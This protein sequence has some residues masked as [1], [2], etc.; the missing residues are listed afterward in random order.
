MGYRIVEVELSETI[1]GV[2]LEP[3]HSG[4]G[5]VCRWHGR[6]VGFIMYQ[7]RSGLSAPQVEALV[8]ERLAFDIL[9]MRAADA[10]S[11]H[12]PAPAPP[13]AVPLS[14]AICTKDRAQRL[15]RLL[16]SL[17]RVVPTSR[18][19]SLEILVIDNASVDDST[20]KVA[21]ICMR[22]F[23]MCASR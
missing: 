5:L 4:V 6:L 22:S 21:E 12:W 18:F 13:S 14:I 1:G 16:V 15:E 3:E 23:A 17:D 20:R 10:M 8:E 9:R 2:G 19:K 11:P 7:A